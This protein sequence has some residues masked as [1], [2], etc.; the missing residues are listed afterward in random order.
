MRY[1]IYH[2]TTYRY[3]HP[4]TFSHN[5]ARLKPKESS[6]QKL[7]N[8]KLSIEPE[9]Y[10]IHEEED[11]FSNTNHHFLIKNSHTYLSV[12]ATSEIEINIASIDE[13]YKN[14]EYKNVTLRE[15]RERLSQ[16]HEDDIDAKMFLFESDLISYV[17]DEMLEYAKK[18]FLPERSLFESVSEFMQRVFDDFE[19]VSG[20]SDITTPVE[21]IFR[22]KKGVCQDFAHLCIATLRTLGIPAKYVSG[23]IQTLPPQ[24][25]EKLFGSD[26]SHAWFSVYILD[27]GWFEF[28]PTNNLIPY[29]QHIILG[30]GRDYFDIAP[31]KGVVQSSGNS[32]LSVMV[33]VKR[34]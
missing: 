27:Y 22:A 29:D 19:F 31:L 13:K 16:F 2:K 25:G 10:E 7:L 4:V 21:E 26:A 9:V 33:D 15:L 3:P 20:F 5:I 8:F 17:N 18:S 24:G 28:D 34:I 11:F 23:Y 1:I 32:L 30:Y 6:H 12:E 14:K